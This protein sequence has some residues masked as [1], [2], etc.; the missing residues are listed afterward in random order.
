M[1]LNGF[2]GLGVGLR[3]LVQSAHDLVGPRQHGPALGVVWIGLEFGGQGLHHL[4]H[5]FL[6]CGL[7][8][9]RTQ[10]R[11]VAQKVV[12]ACGAQGQYQGQQCRSASCAPEGCGGR[13]GRGIGFCGV[14]QQAQ[15]QLV[16]GGL[17]VGRCHGAIGKVALQ[18]IELFAVD[19]GVQSQAGD[20]VERRWTQQGPDHPNDDQHGQGRCEGNEKGHGRRSGACR[21]DC[22]LARWASSSG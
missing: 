9:C 17:I 12:H 6:R 16:A 5:L 20:V 15:L 21:I 7:G 10:R 8:E 18:G 14:V 11:R 1:V 13:C 3:G 2:T 22:A 19:G 4:D